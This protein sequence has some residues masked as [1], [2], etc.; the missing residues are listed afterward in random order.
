MQTLEETNRKVFFFSELL[1]LAYDATIETRT[2]L[3]CKFSNLE[4]MEGSEI[5]NVI[6]DFF[7]LFIC[8]IQLQ[9]SI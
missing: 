4:I 8:M 7:K 3:F 1:L 6:Y 9:I 5:V 2:L